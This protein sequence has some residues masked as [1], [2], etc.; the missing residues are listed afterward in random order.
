MLERYSELEW[1]LIEEAARIFSLPLDQVT[2]SLDDEFID[3]RQ[4]GCIHFTNK[5]NS[6][7][8]RVAKKLNLIQKLQT[9]AHEAVHAHDVLDGCF[10]WTEESSVLFKYDGK[11]V[12]SSGR[13]LDLPWEIK[14]YMMQDEYA[15]NFCSEC[16]VGL[17]RAL[18]D[19]YSLTFKGCE[20]E[21]V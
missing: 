21:N 13:Y 12:C 9:I 16:D 2:I 5:N 1:R 11:W 7:Q 6:I 18:K 15:A 8:I 17:L 4:D 20:D 14:A 19:S 10:E 3:P